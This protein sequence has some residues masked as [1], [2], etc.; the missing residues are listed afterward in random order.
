MAK[1]KAVN[2]P[3]D[4]KTAVLEAVISLVMEG[5]SLEALTV[6]E[7]AARAGIGKKFLKMHVGF[8]GQVLLLL[9]LK[10]RLKYVWKLYRLLMK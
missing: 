1:K 3:Q 10:M 2:S 5:K 7:T 4:K 9:C 8:I 6:S